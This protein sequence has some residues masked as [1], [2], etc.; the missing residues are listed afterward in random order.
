MS[1]SEPSGREDSDTVVIPPPEGIAPVSRGHNAGEVARLS[2]SGPDARLGA[3]SVEILIPTKERDQRAVEDRSGLRRGSALRAGG[4]IRTPPSRTTDDR[5]RAAGRSE[6]VEQFTCRSEN[7]ALSKSSS[8]R[9]CAAGRLSSLQA[10]PQPLLAIAL[11]ISCL[12]FTGPC[13]PIAR[14]PLS[15][16]M[17]RPLQGCGERRTESRREGIISAGSKTPENFSTERRTQAFFSLNLMATPI[18]GWDCTRS[19]THIVPPYRSTSIRER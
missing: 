6:R 8:I 9:E 5:E 19:S 16:G 10:G 17:G 11:E 14:F 1:R 12:G 7:S 3:G 4:A 18:S 15:Q 13:R 2:G